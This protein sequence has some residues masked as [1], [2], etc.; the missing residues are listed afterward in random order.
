MGFGEGRERLCRAYRTNPTC[1]CIFRLYWPF[2]GIHS[3][4]SVLGRHKRADFA[5]AVKEGDGSRDHPWAEEWQLS[6]VHPLR[7]LQPHRIERQV[8]P[9]TSSS[10]SGSSGPP[11]RP[12]LTQG[13]E[14]EQN[15]TAA[16]A[17]CRVRNVQATQS[18]VRFRQA[19]LLELRQ[20][21]QFPGAD[22]AKRGEGKEGH[23]LRVRG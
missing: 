14:T 9:W 10:A 21:L 13:Q 19:A 3:G 22:P 5:V 6:L 16:E 7:C 8:Q 2:C 23:T 4:I 11:I 1:S 20:A 15:A 17:Q 18:T 12:S